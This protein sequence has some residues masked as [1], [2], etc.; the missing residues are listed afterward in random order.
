MDRSSSADYLAGTLAQLLTDAGLDATDDPGGL[1]EII[2][3]ALLMTG[4]AY[5]E[6][7][8]ATVASA[9]VLGYRAVLR[10]AGLL[11]IRDAIAHRVD[12]TLDGPQMSK[13][14]SQA[15]TALDK[16]IEQ[17][18]AAADPFITDS[19]SWGTGTFVLG[20]WIEPVTS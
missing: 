17:A 14:R 16:M 5:D 1:K 13:R 9:D 8:T 7:A 2:D 15:T 18:K 4:T 12:I 11:R 19:G 3:D 20:D 10:F 6:L